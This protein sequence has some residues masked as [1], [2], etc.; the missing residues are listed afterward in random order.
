MAAANARAQAAEA[1]AVQALPAATFQAHIGDTVQVIPSQIQFWQNL[2]G[3]QGRVEEVTIGEGGHQML[4]VEIDGISYDAVAGRFS[5]VARAET[6]QE[7][8]QEGTAVAPQPA[9]QAALALFKGQIVTI[10]VHGTT[11]PFNGLLED[12]TAEGITMMGGALKL[13]YDQISAFGAMTVAAIP[14]MPVPKPKKPGRKSKA[15]KEAEAAAQAAQAPAQAASAPVPVPA[16]P[17]PATAA[18]PLDTKLTLIGG[19]IGDSIKR[20]QEGLHHVQQ[21][22]AMVQQRRKEGQP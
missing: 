1:E 4:S 10:N 9:S 7:T 11:N 21:M 6:A 15:D 2:A 13:R 19:Y 16:A 20:L 12:V 14:G 3:K 5:I 8:A 22:Q 18:V 17:A